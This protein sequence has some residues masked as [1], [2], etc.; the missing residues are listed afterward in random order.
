M[1]GAVALCAYAE[2]CE[3]RYGYTGSEW[4]AIGPFL[5]DTEPADV[6]ERAGDRWFNSDIE[7][8][9]TQLAAAWVGESKTF[10]GGSM[11]ASADPDALLEG[12]KWIDA[13]DRVWLFYNGSWSPMPYVKDIPVGGNPSG[14][15]GLYVYID[16][17]DNLVSH[18]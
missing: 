11:P 15:D 17:V 13:G 1:G 7:R 10:R 6:G 18:F 4:V 3:V 2:D 14:V 5:G 8:W 12:D 16:G 9:Y